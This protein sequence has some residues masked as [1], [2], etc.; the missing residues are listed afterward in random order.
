MNEHTVV[1]KKKLKNSQKALKLATRQ[2]PLTVHRSEVIYET[3]KTN[4]PY[5]AQ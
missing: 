5:I 2:T 3:L 4:K 1:E